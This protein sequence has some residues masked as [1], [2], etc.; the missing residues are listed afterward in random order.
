[1][2][3]NSTHLCPRIIVMVKE[4]IFSENDRLLIITT[5]TSYRLDWSKFRAKMTTSISRRKFDKRLK[6][7]IWFRTKHWF[8][9][10]WAYMTT[11]LALQDFRPSPMYFHVIFTKN[12][13]QTSFETDCL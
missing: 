3:T 12:L 6:F 7:S 4:D 9:R 2:L 13:V 11:I 5:E 8:M 10:L 1:M